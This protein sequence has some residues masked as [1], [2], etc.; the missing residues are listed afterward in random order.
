MK[1]TALL[2]KSLHAPVSAAQKIHIKV[3]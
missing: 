3:G 1:Y 2:A